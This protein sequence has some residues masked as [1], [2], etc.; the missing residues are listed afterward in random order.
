MNFVDHPDGLFCRDGFH[1][2]A[3]AHALW[4]EQLAALAF[5]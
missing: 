3:R 4:A 2:N 5:E 1:P